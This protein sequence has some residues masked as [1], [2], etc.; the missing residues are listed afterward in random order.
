[1][2][3]FESGIT[4]DMK[5]AR[6]DKLFYCRLNEVQEVAER[7]LTG[8]RSIAVLGDSKLASTLDKSWNILKI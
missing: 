4:D 2:S 5:Q 8:E 3:L 7:Y 1:M 6:R